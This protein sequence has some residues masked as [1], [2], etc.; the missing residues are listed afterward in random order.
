LNRLLIILFFYP[1]VIFGQIEQLNWG[2]YTTIS[3]NIEGYGRPRIVLTA[4]DD[5]LIIWRKDASP[6]V[7][8]ASKWN[9]NTFSAPYDILSPGIIP[10]SWDGPEIAAKGDTVYIVFTSSATTTTS[11][12][13]I[14]SFD[15]GLS[16]SDTIRVSENNSN[17]KFRMSNVMVKPDGNPV[18]SYM[19]YLLN[20]MEPKQM[21]T[22]SFNYGDSFIM[23]TE[24]S[25]IAPGEPCDCC[26][27]SLVVSSVD[28]I[29]LLFRNNHNNER[30]S[31]ISKS[32]DGGN[33]FTI[34]EDMDDY[35]WVLNSCPATT[36]RG[37][38]MNDSL[39]IVK[40]S[41]ATGNNEIV[42]SSIHI[43]DLNYS[44]NRNIDFINGVE[45]DYPEISG[46]QDTVVVVWQDNRNGFQNCYMSL[47]TNGAFNL[48]SS[49]S[50]TDSTSIGYKYDP[51][52]AYANRDIHLVYLD[53]TQYK[54]VYVKASFDMINEAQN[55][56]PQ[57][58]KITRVFDMLGRNLNNKN[59]QILFYIKED[60]T[61][62]KQMVVK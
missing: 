7:L 27:S 29:F 15:G 20:W 39:V 13:L 56:L 46:N 4:N 51:D 55:L 58:K 32:V 17:H 33:S 26:K 52:V 49:I 28:D 53:Y 59:N 2:S 3:S 14:R 16:F 37:I 36:P 5:P 24:A 44:Y 41:G 45:Q 38:V 61:V 34:T 9:G 35:D 42:C 8:R 31:Y 21:V 18:V 1:F 50:F 57:E 62:K 10:A 22:T 43:N 60:G 19:Q 30:N 23:P 54:I 11:I 25:A 40:R 47:S 12:M 6:K 48:N